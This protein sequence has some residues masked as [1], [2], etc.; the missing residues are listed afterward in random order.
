MEESIQLLRKTIELSEDTDS[1]LPSYL[2][3]LASNLGSR[4]AILGHIE[5]LE[6]GIRLG[7]QAITTSRI[8]EVQRATLYNKL[9]ALLHQRFVEGGTLFDID[10]AIKLTATGV[11]L[12][13]EQDP[14]RGIY[15]FELGGHYLEKYARTRDD[16]VVM[17]A[18]RGYKIAID[19]PS[20][21]IRQRISA[22]AMA[23]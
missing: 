6:E 20:G 1:D 2:S 13:S 7:R 5:D 4:F 16:D 19:Q 23:M 9:A 22:S 18:M 21:Q 11:S 17:D 15:A 10:E 14:P 12:A 8:S 3:R